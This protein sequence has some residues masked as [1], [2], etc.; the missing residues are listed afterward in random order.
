MEGCPVRGGVVSS[1]LLIEGITILRRLL[2]RPLCTVIK[3]MAYALSK[4]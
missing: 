4:W 3:P 1:V 2:N